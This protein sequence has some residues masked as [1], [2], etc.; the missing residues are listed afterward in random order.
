MCVKNITRSFDNEIVRV[1][2][3]TYKGEPHL[4][5][6]YIDW[7]GSEVQYLTDCR[8]IAISREWEHDITKLRE[9]LCSYYGSIYLGD[10]YTA[11]IYKKYALFDLECV[12]RDLDHEPTREVNFTQYREEIY[13]WK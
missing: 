8:Y 5:L 3:I 6:S 4:A 1:S 2:I 9:G 10:D 7:S 11:G 12:W 13:N